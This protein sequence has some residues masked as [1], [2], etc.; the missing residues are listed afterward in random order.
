MNFSLDGIGPVL[1]VVGCHL[2]T[3]ENNLGMDNFMANERFE[4]SG[5]SGSGVCLEAMLLHVRS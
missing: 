4:L 3:P 1:F 2:S 5:A